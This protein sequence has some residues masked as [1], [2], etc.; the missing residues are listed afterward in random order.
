MT[1][2]SSNFDKTNKYKSD[3]I[4]TI[5]KRPELQIKFFHRYQYFTSKIIKKWIAD[6]YQFQS[7]VIQDDYVNYK[8]EDII[9]NMPSY[10][11][12][13]VWLT[14]DIKNNILFNW[15]SNHYGV[16][17]LSINNMKGIFIRLKGLFNNEKEIFDTPSLQNMILSLMINIKLLL[18]AY[19]VSD[20]LIL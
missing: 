6:Y 7:K 1:D 18:R 16:I 3:D 10:N 2:M 11:G 15:C 5:F 4:N 20:H 8:Y 14:K 13:F 9:L 17:D 12:S 19:K